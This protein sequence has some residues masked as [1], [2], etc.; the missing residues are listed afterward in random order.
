[1]NED[2]KLQQ[3]V[4]CKTIL[5]KRTHLMLRKNIVT[6]NPAAIKDLILSS[7]TLS[8]KLQKWLLMKVQD[9]WDD[10]SPLL[11]IFIQ[12]L[13]FALEAR[14]TKS[15]ILVMNNVTYIFELNY[16]KVRNHCT[17]LQTVCYIKWKVVYYI[18]DN[19]CRPAVTDI[20]FSVFL[21]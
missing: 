1:M 21:K 16:I 6:E 18:I 8:Y 11:L 2:G 15:S 9:G 5:Y 3:G 12:E 17:F 20:W 4:G 10:S 14:K 19:K 13:A 7:S